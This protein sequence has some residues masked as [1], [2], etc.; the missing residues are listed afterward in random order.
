[1]YNPPINQHAFPLLWKGW[2]RSLTEGKSPGW[3]QSP[4]KEALDFFPFPIFEEADSDP[5]GLLL[6]RFLGSQVR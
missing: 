6:F 1:M 5:I 2:K 4:G 3:K